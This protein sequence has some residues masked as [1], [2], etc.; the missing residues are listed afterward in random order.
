MQKYSQKSVKE[1]VKQD[2]D[3]QNTYLKCK[4][5]EYSCKKINIMRKHMNMEHADNIFKICDKVFTNSMD[6]LVHTGK[7]HSQNITEDKC[8]IRK[9]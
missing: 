1:E 2:K 6:A 4:M 7:Y 8:T 9:S 3:K 5:C